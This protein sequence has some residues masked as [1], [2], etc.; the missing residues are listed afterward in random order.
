MSQKFSTAI[1]FMLQ[2]NRIN[3]VSIY[4]IIY[5]PKYI[6]TR[7]QMKMT[8][9]REAFRLILIDEMYS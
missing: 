5:V 4:A 3:L 8:A 6:L 7:E 1:I 2:A 9:I